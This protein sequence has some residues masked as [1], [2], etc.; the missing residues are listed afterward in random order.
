MLKVA[1]LNQAQGKISM[2]I[3]SVKLLVLEN[4][5]PAGAVSNNYPKA[6]EGGNSGDGSPLV[7][8]DP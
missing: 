8:G 5:Q 4:P 1:V 3:E 6:I 7:L 2:K